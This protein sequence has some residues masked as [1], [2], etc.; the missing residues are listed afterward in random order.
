MAKIYLFISLSLSLLLLLLLL[1]L[2]SLS[3]FL[4]LTQ[5]HATRLY[6]ASYI[7][8][9]DEV[10]ELLEEGANVN[11]PND[12]VRKIVS[13]SLSLYHN[14]FSTPMT[15]ALHTENRFKLFTL[16][17]VIYPAHVHKGYK[18]ISFVCHLSPQNL[19]DLASEWLKHVSGIEQMET[20]KNTLLLLSACH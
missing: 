12:D 16:K 13:C 1:L 7:G 14:N 8:N 9:I 15:S 5:A 11:E 20:V 6:Q 3:L 18:A 2:L 4:S 10:K 17:H 19:L